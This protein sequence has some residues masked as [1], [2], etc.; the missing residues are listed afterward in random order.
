[1]DFLTSD[2]WRWRFASDYQN[3]V[4]RKARQIYD[5]EVMRILELIYENEGYPALDLPASLKAK[6]IAAKL[7][8]IDNRKVPGFN[9]GA[10]KLTTYLKIT[11]AGLQL[12]G[13][14]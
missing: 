13:K 3:P 7:V 2:P 4:C 8:E 14:D 1:M 10:F 9:P 6:L 5:N 12:I 11:F